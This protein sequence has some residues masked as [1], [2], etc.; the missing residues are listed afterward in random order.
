[1]KLVEKEERKLNIR[2]K[3]FG[4]CTKKKRE[5]KKIKINKCNEHKQQQQQH[6][7]L[8]DLSQDPTANIYKE[9]KSTI[10]V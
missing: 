5:N 6:K 9:L 8:V 10:T 1:M 3:K 2:L 4:K 7:I